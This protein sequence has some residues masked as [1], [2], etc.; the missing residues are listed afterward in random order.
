MSFPRQVTFDQY[1][2]LVFA[3]PGW[4]EACVGMLSAF[5]QDIDTDS[6]DAAERL[7]EIAPSIVEQASAIV[8]AAKRL[9]QRLREAAEQRGPAFQ[10]DELGAVLW[11]AG[12]A[13]YKATSAA[14]GAR[15]RMAEQT[16]DDAFFEIH[17]LL[18]GA[19]SAL[20]LLSVAEG[21]MR[22]ME[23]EGTG[24]ERPN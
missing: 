20:S 24:R 9:E 13:S 6:D 21:M 18:H 7:P 17:A 3:G 19:I 4:L 14:E 5:L 22:R 15:G 12:M 1:L 10:T 16:W 23:A 11:W 8:G 2:D